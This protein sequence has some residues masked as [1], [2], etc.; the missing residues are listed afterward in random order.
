[1]ILHVDMDAFYASVEIMD[2]PALKDRPVIVGGLGRRGVVSAASYA[3]RP[4]GVHSAMPMFMALQK[5]PEAIVIKPNM[6][7]YSAVSREIMAALNKFSP[8]VLKVSIDEA[9][10]DMNDSHYLYE[11]TVSMIM[12]IKKAVY[13]VYP[14]TCSIGAAPVKFLAKVVSDIN[15]PNGYYIVEEA[16]MTA[17]IDRLPVEKV[18]GVGK[19]NAESLRLLGVTC[20]G[21]LKRLPENIV[22]QRLGKNGLHLL[23]L[24]H[25][26]DIRHLEPGQ[27]RKSLGSE[28]TLDENT[29]DLE[30]L[31]AYLLT[32][33][34][35]VG[36]GVRMRG[37]YFSTVTLKIKYGDFT[38]QTRQTTLPFAA[39]ST[40][41]IYDTAC[42]LLAG[43]PLRQPLRLIG[44]SVSGFGHD[45]AEQLYLF[46]TEREDESWHK[47]DDAV[48][49]IQARFGKNAVVN[50][51]VL[52]LKEKYKD[53]D[54]WE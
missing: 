50:A 35:E 14:L 42:E 27:A 4:Y 33:A 46:K 40:K 47:V 10:L 28:H 9:Y 37:L 38:T 25:G 36:N 19:R 52:K 12:A 32:Q 1:M 51:S 29:A 43:K 13:E 54:D 15:K 45:K 17:F 20:L 3:V 2:N 8:R 11:D 23:D 34:H 31:K 6:E 5:C 26:R 16:D 21:D 48:D 18:P 7:R 22:A 24:A 39:C 41:T 49:A 53:E 30:I 44:V